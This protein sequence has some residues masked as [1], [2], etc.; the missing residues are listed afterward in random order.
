MTKYTGFVG[1]YTKGDSKG[2]YS[3]TLDTSLSKIMDVQVAAELENPTYLTVSENNQFIYSVVK[4]GD[5]GGV[6]ALSLDP[7]TGK[8][9]HLNKVT[10]AGSPPC[11]VSVGKE[12][13][14]VFSANYHK[15]TIESYL[16]N[17]DGTILPATSVVEHHGS[18]P[19]PRQDK[20]HTHYSAFTP[21]EKFVIAVELGADKIFSYEVSNG[22]L[23]EINQLTVK[24]G[25]GPRH[26]VF[27][28]TQKFAY[29]MTEFS[30]EVIVLAYNDMDASFT[31]IEYKSTLPESFSENNQG[32]AIHISSDGKFIYAGNRGH[33][34]IA[35]FKVNEENGTLTF[36]EH[37]STEGNWPRDFVL[38]PSEKF[39]VAS[40]QESS[41]LVLFS[42][43]AQ[44]GKLTLIQSDINVPDPVCVKFLNYVG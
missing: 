21:D 42:R 41:N 15:G 9:T 4:D 39:I 34:T 22:V 26:I 8:L 17:E 36:V 40:N 12:N 5:E 19:D 18:G 37:T 35:I 7:Q 29:V 2:I 13:R 16:I 27:H 20:P 31:E 10:T 14:N 30:S 38:D 23:K 43:D 32:S 3:F 6:G 44:T 11:H 1:T 33:N 24:S 25:S 28:P